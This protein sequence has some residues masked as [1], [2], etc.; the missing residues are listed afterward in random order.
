MCSSLEHVLKNNNNNNNGG[1]LLPAPVCHFHRVFGNVLVNNGLKFRDNHVKDSQTG[2]AVGDV[3]FV[4]HEGVSFWT[5]RV[6][7]VPV[8]AGPRP[9]VWREAR[10]AGRSLWTV[11]DSWLILHFI[12]SPGLFL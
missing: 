9:A 11:R 6:V 8:G 5:S 4:V 1:W 7:C 3:S 12:L 2:Q 10:C